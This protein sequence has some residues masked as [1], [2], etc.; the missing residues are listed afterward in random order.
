[1]QTQEALAHINYNSPGV[2]LADAGDP[3][4]STG[5]SA[6]AKNAGQENAQIIKYGVAKYQKDQKRSWYVIGYDGSGNSVAARKD[7]ITLLYTGT[8][9]EEHLFNSTTYF[10]SSNE[11]A[12]SD[13][14]DAIS[15]FYFGGYDWSWH[16]PIEQKAVVRRTLEGGSKN[17]NQEGYDPNKVKGDGLT[18]YFWSLSKEQGIAKFSFFHA[19]T[20]MNAVTSISQSHWPEQALSWFEQCRPADPEKIPTEDV[21]TAPANG[22]Q[23]V[24]MLLSEH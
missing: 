7:L 13:V 11:Y 6:L 16:D 17:M 5:A 23:M 14:R 24:I 18:E 3:G 21:Q 4:I 19:S 20:I 22:M 10:N 1:M 15:S 9:T 12:T 8:S 2:V